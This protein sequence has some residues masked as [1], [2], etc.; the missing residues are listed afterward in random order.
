KISLKLTWRATRVLAVASVL[1]L[2]LWAALVNAMPIRAER[3]AALAATICFGV[4]PLLLIAANV[5]LIPYE[6]YIQRAYEREAIQRVKG[7]AP[8]IIG[9]TGSYGKSSAKAMLA[10]ILQYKG[11]TLAASGSINTLM[12]V[13]RHIREELVPG[14]QFM[15][16]EMGAFRAG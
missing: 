13:T 12:G 11:P 3:A 2:G 9:I 4:A 6:R 15:V 16:V 5:C 8:F 10:H 1:A 7:V 14:H